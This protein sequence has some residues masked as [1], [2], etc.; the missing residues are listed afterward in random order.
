MKIESFSVP[1]GQEWCGANAE[2]RGP[3]SKK[4]IAKCFCSPGYEG[5]GFHCEGKFTT[6]VHLL[7]VTFCK[8]EVQVMPAGYAVLGVVYHGIFHKSLFFSFPSANETRSISANNRS[9]LGLYLTV[10]CNH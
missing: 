10:T 5:D 3:K 4:F 6:N 1:G 2:F 9:T 7:H 8:A